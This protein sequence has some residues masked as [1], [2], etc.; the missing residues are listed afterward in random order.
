MENDRLIKILFCL[1]IGGALLSIPLFV[2]AYDP[3][4][5]HAALTQEMAKVFNALHP[6]TALSDGDSELL[7]KGAMDEDGGTRWMKHFYDPVYGRGFT[8]AAGREWQDSRAW[9]QDTLAQA[10]SGGAFKSRAYGSLFSLFSSDHDY[11]WDRAVYGYAWSDKERGLEALGH[12][13]HLLEDAGVPDHTR[14][15]A[16]P[17][18]FHFGS[19][20]E[21]W[22]KRFTPDNVHIADA[23][24]TTEP[25]R[26]F[27]DLG[28]YFDFMAVYSNSNFF[29]KDSILTSE[30]TGPTVSFSRIE[31]DD[32]GLPTKYGFGKI[33][34]QEYKLVK[35]PNLPE[36]K[37]LG[38]VYRNEY[39]LDDENHLIVADYW[40]LL[41]REAVLNGAGV[42][43]LFFKEVEK[44]KETKVLWK[45]NRSWGQR[46]W[47]WFSE[48]S[49]FAGPIDVANTGPQYASLLAAVSDEQAS[50][51]TAGAHEQTPSAPPLSTDPRPVEMPALPPPGIVLGA[52]AEGGTQQVPIVVAPA[53]TQS[54]GVGGVF[55]AGSDS[56]APSPASGG[57]QAASAAP[58]P[59]EPTPPP[60]APD[61]T[62]PDVE[63]VIQECGESISLELC[64][65]MPGTLHV[66][67]HLSADDIASFTVACE[68]EAA[69]EECAQLGT[70][71]ASTTLFMSVAGDT[72]LTFSVLAADTAGN[73]S[74]AVKKSVTVVSRPVVINEIAWAGTG[75]GALAGDE[76]LELANTSSHIISLDGWKLEFV[77]LGTTT[78]IHTLPLA[79]ALAPEGYFLIESDDGAIA[80]VSADLISSFGEG[81]SDGGMTLVLRDA[82]SAL[83]DVTPALCRNGWCEGAI[84]GRYT[85]ERIRKEAS[86]DGQANWETWQFLE[87]AQAHNREGGG[88][89]GTPRARNSVNYLVTPSGRI[90]GEMTLV[91]NRSPYII[92]A[93]GLKLEF[94]AVLTI[95]PGVVIKF[96]STNEPSFDVYGKITANGTAE[97]SVAF[98][99]IFDDTYG[100][101]TNGDGACGTD[102]AA[103]CPLPGEWKRI[104][105]HAE[106]P[107]AAFTHTA[108]RYGGRWFSGQ[109]FR[110]MIAVEEAP[111]VFDHGMFEY[112]F[113]HGLYSIDTDLEVS[114]STF[115][116]NNAAGADA[117]LVAHGTPII[118][119]SLFDHNATGLML[120]GT[121]AGEVRGNTFTENT[122]AI[123]SHESFAAFSGNQSSGAG[124]NGILLSGI[125]NGDYV[126]SDGGIPYV[127]QDGTLRLADGH[128]FRAEAGVVIKFG[129]RASGL[130]VDGEFHVAGTPEAPVVF[131]ALADDEYGGDTSGDGVTAGSSGLWNAMAFGPTSGDSV[132]S[133]ALIRY[134]GGLRFSPFALKISGVPITVED[135]IFEYNKGIGLWL[136]SS[137][138]AISRTTF[139]HHIVPENA[140]ALLAADHTTATLDAVV[141]DENGR[142]VVTDDTSVVEGL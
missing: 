110:T 41:S 51:N 33:K 64:A 36:W 16:H 136:I 11:S 97:E 126:F 112:S 68:S 52:S 132:I 50:N 67:W 93:D 92:S 21:S 60:L 44:E 61:T 111:A 115:R 3:T 29:S 63:L 131:T 55:G 140:I 74:E 86:G 85:M 118:R 30:Y 142:N 122:Q 62:A 129:T 2:Y 137:D 134:G 77:P 79:G 46:A 101:D 117:L 31:W 32:A 38:E 53:D 10:Q 37:L 1:Y 54:S 27:T 120:S 65:V 47:D 105:V 114:N 22:T 20:Y 28:A 72:T 116:Y 8:T 109:D 4:T 18:I 88:I 133:G 40:N 127:V 99:S 75:A 141:F 107:G 130:V 83:V 49:P 78:P 113:N 56:P 76:W 13:L 24:G 104:H 57:E 123:D 14:N 71:T 19:P 98:T 106:S 23:I 108:F 7:K 80:S 39:K 73:R 81:L 119:D 138:A 5:A 59:S 9:A 125:L 124:V 25:M 35:M 34:N 43:D 87:M 102:A 128:V 103:Q 94:G 89:N 95:D 121:E 26:S 66:S 48:L 12:V 100:G 58:T 135:S 91:K 90:T 6:A 42:I 70:T 96:V 45:K 17:D 69:N 139:R 82:H 84:A 15:D